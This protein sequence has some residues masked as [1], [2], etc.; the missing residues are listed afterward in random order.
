MLDK[1]L[2]EFVLFGLQILNRT[3]N[4]KQ[5]IV[6]IVGNSFSKR[7]GIGRVVIKISFEN[8]LDP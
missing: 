1:E 7:E 6:D 4:A 8:A 2:E 3:V 5:L